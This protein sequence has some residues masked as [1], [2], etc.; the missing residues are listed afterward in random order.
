MT[1]V[2]YKEALG[3]MVVYDVTRSGT[4]EGVVKWKE[5]INNKVKFPGTEEPIPTV[6]LCNKIDLIDVQ[7]RPQ[8]NAELDQFCEDHG[9]IGWFDTSAKDNIG[10]DDAGNFLVK[11][12][13]T[14]LDSL[15]KVKFEP[16]ESVNLD[17]NS[18]H[19]GECGC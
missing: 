17:A 6:L 7:S 1:R 14:R 12:I 19:S 2:Y 10:I 11:A 15:P 9:F 18:N 3:A 8:T 5:D 4:F 13:L 16:K